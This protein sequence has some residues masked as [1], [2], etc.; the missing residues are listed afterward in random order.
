MQFTFDGKGQLDRF[1]DIAPECYRGYDTGHL[2][3]FHFE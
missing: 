2:Y 1:D 3:A